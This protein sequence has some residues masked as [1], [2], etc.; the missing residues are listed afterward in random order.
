VI[1]TCSAYGL[2]KKFAR[3]LLVRVVSPAEGHGIMLKKALWTFEKVL[4]INAVSPPGRHGSHPPVVKIFDQ[5]T[6]V[7]QS[8]KCGALIVNK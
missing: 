2:L 5:K 4:R 3:N 8:S 1:N 7:I 6:S